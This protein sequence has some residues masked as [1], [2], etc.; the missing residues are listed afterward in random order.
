MELGDVQRHRHGAPLDTASLPVERQVRHA[1]ETARALARWNP[2]DDALAALL[3]AEIIGLDQV[4][5]H[6]LSR[7][8]VRAILTRP[9]RP[10][11][12]VE[13]SDRMGARSG[14]PRCSWAQISRLV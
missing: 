1:I 7:D 11:L 12:A 8:L 14:G 3:D 4:R 10:R 2:I 9:R 5:Y 13:L 6:R